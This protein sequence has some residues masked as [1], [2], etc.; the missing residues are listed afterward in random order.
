[1]E[2]MSAPDG[3]QEGW[4]LLSRIKIKIPKKMIIF[5]L[6]GC[7]TLL[8][9]MIDNAVKPTIFELSESKLK[10]LAV[11]AMNDAVAETISGVKYSDL[12]TVQKD[13]NNRVTMLQA[14][15]LQMNDLAFKAA[16]K[17][18]DTIMNL[19][20][21]GIYIPLGT[22]LGGQ[23]LSG[24]GPL[25]RID[26]IPVGSVTSRFSSEF[27][28]A[29]IN[30]TRHKIYITLNASIRIVVGNT[31][32]LIDV[33]Q[34]VLISETVIIGSVPNTFLESAREDLMNL[35]PTDQ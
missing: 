4:D 9:F 16:L 8:Y 34:Q 31:G 21:Q 10:Y 6:L 32:Q 12:I 25:I 35:I 1:M 11:K 17:A 13:A 27:E 14:N 28:T 33:S 23:L 30:Q 7:I 29:G 24:K 3:G 15:T 19:G 2:D 22:A 26:I 20:A 18:Q 5:I